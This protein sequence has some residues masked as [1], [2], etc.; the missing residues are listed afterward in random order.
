MNH[1]GFLAQPGAAT[2]ALPGNSQA[3]IKNET[4]L[5][6]LLNQA[7]DVIFMA[8]SVF[9]FDLFPDKLQIDFTKITIT[10]R[11]FFF[12]KHIESVLIERVADAIVETSPF[13]ASLVIQDN[14]MPD[15]AIRIKFLKWNDAKRARKMIL[16][17]KI[18]KERGVDFSNVNRDDM[19]MKIEE[20][21]SVYGG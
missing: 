12:T 13:F 3:V 14:F 17:L 8:R 19:A 20:L 18:A 16:G 11:S 15:K 6:D 2:Q 9:P 7:K 5:D 4:R 10:Q 21:G 1:P